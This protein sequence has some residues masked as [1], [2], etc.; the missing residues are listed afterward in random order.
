LYGYGLGLWD[1]ISN[2]EA[3]LWGLAAFALQAVLAAWWFRHYRYG[4]LEWV[5]RAATRTTTAVP[6][7]QTA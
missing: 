4:P 3:V 6:F 7:R 5:W 1:E 2:A